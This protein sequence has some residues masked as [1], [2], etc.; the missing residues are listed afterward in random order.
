MAAADQVTRFSAGSTSYNFFSTKRRSSLSATRVD[1]KMG[2]ELR[3][4]RS[5]KWRWIGDCADRGIIWRARPSP[6]AFSRKASEGYPGT[7]WHRAWKEGRCGRHK[8]ANRSTSSR[9]RRGLRTTYPVTG[10]L[11]VT[12]SQRSDPGSRLRT[13]GHRRPNS[14]EDNRAPKSIELLRISEDIQE[15]I[16]KMVIV[17]IS[18]EELA[19]FGDN[20]EI[21]IGVDDH[22]ARET[23]AVH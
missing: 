22:A 6:G 1:S 10:N 9:Q 19:V 5:G 2:N 14:Y 8:R 4:R 21:T 11:P 3:D 12:V 13:D 17:R 20:F 23:K 16:E 15:V 7:E 18:A